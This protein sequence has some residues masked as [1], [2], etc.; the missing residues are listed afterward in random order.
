MPPSLVLSVLLSS[1]VGLLFHSVLGRRLWQLPL[2]WGGAVLGFF[3]GEVLAVV[4]HAEMFRLGNIPLAPALLG[5]VVVLGICW[6][7]STP[8]P[9]PAE[10]RVQRQSRARR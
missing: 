8:P 6:F 5:S 1:I 2:Y 4:A 9:G 10:T 3:G 7:F